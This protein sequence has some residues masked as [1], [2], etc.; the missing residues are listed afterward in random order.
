VGKLLP[1]PLILILSLTILSCARPVKRSAPPAAA[2]ESA[3]AQAAPPA[4]QGQAP[5]PPQV[6][7]QPQ[8]PALQF[9]AS[10][11]PAGKQ[12][13]AAIAVQPKVEGGVTAL[14]AQGLEKKIM[15]EDFL[16]GALSETDGRKAEEI[17]AIWTARAFLASIVAGAPNR[18][19]LSAESEEGIADMLS[20]SAEQGY[21]AKSFR[22][23]NP[24]RHENGEVTASVRLL[25]A[26]AS[27][28]G[29]IYLSRTGKEWLVSDFQINL[30][31]LATKREKP[32]ERFFPS[33][34]RWLLE[35]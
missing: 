26:E 10:P 15:P 14:V 35:E 9:P 12:K 11:S 20:F 22:L 29:E 24:K 21:T 27:S 2:G 34:Y 1:V 4:A 19:L 32:K 6:S 17:E 31:Q 8:S 16:I 30:A 13:P 23:G 7:P 33:A 18:K 28:E 25:D 5:S 3:A